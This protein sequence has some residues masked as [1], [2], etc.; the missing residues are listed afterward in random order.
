MG[1]VIKNATLL[2]VRINKF[3]E[4]CNSKPCCLC[5]NFLK[6]FGVFKIYYSTDNGDIQSYNIKYESSDHYSVGFKIMI[7]TIN[8]NGNVKSYRLPP[9]KLPNIKSSNKLQNIE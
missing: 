1:S 5:E 9:I 4:L 7:S 3:G 8:N 2:V 6:S